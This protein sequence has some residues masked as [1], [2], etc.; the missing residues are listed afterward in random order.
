MG[1]LARAGRGL[2]SARSWRGVC[3]RD[4]FVCGEVLWLPRSSWARR[5]NGQAG[6]GLQLGTVKG[7]GVVGPEVA[8]HHLQR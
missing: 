4:V 3:G 1:P 2:C 7:E 6:M 8:L 5:I